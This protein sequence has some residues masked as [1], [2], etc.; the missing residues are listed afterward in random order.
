MPQRSTP[1]STL[2]ED[3]SPDAVIGAVERVLRRPMSNLCRSLN[4]YINRVFEL[5]TSDGHG[6]IAKFYRPGRWSDAALQDEHDFLFELDDLELPVVSP[7]LDVEGRSVF[8]F[9]G[10]RFALFPKQL[11]RAVDE[12][13]EEQWTQLGR[14]LA[15]VHLVGA[16]RA[17]RDRVRLT[18]DAV[19]LE[20]IRYVVGHDVV[21][22]DLRNQWRD[23]AMRIVERIT[24]QF[25]GVELIR[26][27]GDCQPSNI[28]TR[29]DDSLH[30]I[31]FDDM[32]VGPAV[33]D[34]WMFLPDY[35]NRSMVEIELVLDGYETFRRF[36]R[37]ELRL[38]EPLRAMRIIYFTAWCA[39]Q[40][41]DVG[42]TRL[43]PNWGTPGFW[44]TAIRDLG[45]QRARIEAEQGGENP[46]NPMYS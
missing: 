42:H 20:N 31:D 35:G 10:T 44:R 4:S 45:E 11:G 23:E 12:L 8:L 13:S 46:T 24:P 40:I 3:L 17:P 18:P 27:H 36:D 22:R 26:I 15:R 1:P 30:L 9:D 38:I 29:G 5:Q 28:V 25:D 14:L 2:F 39:M 21:P 33:H 7:I 32:S 37:R 19:T 41:A 6:V 43:D 34:F 16:M